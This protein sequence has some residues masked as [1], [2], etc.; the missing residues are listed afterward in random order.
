MESVGEMV[1]VTGQFKSTGTEAFATATNGL[2]SLS[3]SCDNGEGNSASLF[4]IDVSH[5]L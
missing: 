1:Y 5:K 2:G 4:A 3:S